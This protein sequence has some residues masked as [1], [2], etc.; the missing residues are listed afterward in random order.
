MT[1]Y[2][3]VP[4]GFNRKPLAVILAEIEEK[5]ITEFGPDVIQTS[6]S[7]LGQINGLVAD[8]VAELWEE[9]EGLYQSYD[10]S[11]AD[12]VRLDMLGRLRLVSRNGKTDGQYR[13]VITNVGQGRID[14]QDLAQALASI[15]GVTFARV[16]L[17]EGNDMDLGA[18]P[19]G[20]VAVAV[21]GGDDAL[22]ANVLRRYIVPGVGTY[23]NTRVSTNING[24]CRSM[25]IIRP[26]V[27]PVELTVVI[28]RMSDQQNC[29]PPSVDAI[30]ATLAGAW[31]LESSNGTDPSFY[32]VRTIIERAFSNVEVVSVTGK[33]EETTYPTNVSVPISFLEIATLSK[34][35]IVQEN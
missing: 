7:P 4:T 1:E 14:L 26:V 32:T 35:T 18:L 34:I 3:I 33:R 19:P 29:P 13:Q 30:A 21:I 11:Q 28:H 10:P 6:Q 20:F 8:L 15:P 17:N 24:F 2:G 31:P 9:A 23:G 16:F 12:G 5:N 22:I 25:S 27:V